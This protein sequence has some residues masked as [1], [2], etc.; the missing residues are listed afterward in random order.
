MNYILLYH[1]IDR[2]ITDGS[3]NIVS[4]TKTIKYNNSIQIQKLLEKQFRLLSSLIKRKP[5]PYMQTI[6]GGR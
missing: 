5:K 2:I 6:K 1:L 4:S 3:N